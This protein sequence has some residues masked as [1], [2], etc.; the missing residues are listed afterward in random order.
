MIE[1]FADKNA[2]LIW[3]GELAKKLPRDIQEDAR[4]VLRI[5]PPMLIDQGE[6]ADGLARLDKAFGEVKFHD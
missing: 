5:A 6:I 4:D 2:E 1:S 3:K